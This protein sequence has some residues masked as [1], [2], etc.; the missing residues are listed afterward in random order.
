MKNKLH[1]CLAI[2]MLL[3]FAACGSVS[4]SHR[5]ADVLRKATDTPEAFVPKEGI[6]LSST[7]CVSPM[8][9]FRSG[10][11]IT[12]VS[13][14]SGYGVYKVPAGHYGVEEGELLRLD[15]ATG[16]ALGIVRE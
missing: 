5:H 11:E 7:T 9:D 3:L 13:S 12:L 10:V 14:E 8:I 2:V 16:K 6:S 4:T 15:C 1:Y